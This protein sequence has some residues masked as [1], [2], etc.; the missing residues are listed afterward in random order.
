MAAKHKKKCECLGNCLQWNEL[1]KS[2][3]KRKWTMQTTPGRTNMG[4]L[5]PPLIM[6]L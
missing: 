6:R 1:E 4:G 2:M 5:F 3:L